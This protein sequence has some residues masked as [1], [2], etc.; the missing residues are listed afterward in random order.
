MAALQSASAITNKKL[1]GA[2][3]TNTE[4]L[5][6]LMQRNKLKAA[7]VATILGRE[8]NTVRVWRVRD[9]KRVIPDDTLTVLEVKLAEKRRR[10][11]ARRKASGRAA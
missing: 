11:L 3:H 9:T 6:T 10:R 8:V 4:R 2:M 1:A 5:H 7:D